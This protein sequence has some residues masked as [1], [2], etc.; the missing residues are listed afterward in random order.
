MAGDFSLKDY[1]ARI[2]F[3]GTPAADLATLGAIHAAHVGTIPFENLDPLLGRPVL[4]DIG[5]LQDKMVHGRRGG[6]C[7]E[8]NTLLR[9]ALEAIGFHVTG[10]AGRVRWMSPPDAPLGP[11]TH[12]LLK[13]DLADGPWLADVGF[14]GCLLDQP[15]RL[16]A[17]IEQRTGAGT[18]QLSVTE[19]TFSLTGR[20]SAGW[21][22]LY[23]F[24]LA[25]Q[26][27]SDYEMA[28]WFTSTNPRLVLLQNLIMER[29]AGGRRYKL[30]NRRFA[31]EEEDGRAVEGRN[32][33]T[34][35]DLDRLLRET[36][37]VEPPVP[38]GQIFARLGAS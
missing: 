7:F 20:Q 35:E 25:P 28:N 22:T 12:M 31:V 27:K 16:E 9:A 13:V 14:G 30:V 5:A 24:D 21:R 36:F 11:R 26:E 18:Y 32:V 19:G 17:G 38:A 29:V 10:L 33:E 4:L 37:G 2:G 34:A 6:Y 15:L 3:A 1:L 23:A 8:Q